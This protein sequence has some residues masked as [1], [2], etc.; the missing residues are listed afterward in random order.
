MKS[1]ISSDEEQKVVP[2]Y[3][4]VVSVSQNIKQRRIDE[5]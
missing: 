2:Q 4:Q 3:S 5:L 1:E